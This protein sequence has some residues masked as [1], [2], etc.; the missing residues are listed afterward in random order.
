MQQLSL[1]VSRTAAILFIVSSA[2]RAQS[3]ADNQFQQEC[4][5]AGKRVERG[6]PEKKLDEAFLTLQACGSA[7][8]SR[9]LASALQSY[10]GE[11]DPLR[12]QEFM[13]NVDSWRDASVLQAARDV[14]SSTA[15]TMEARV[16]AIRHLL[17]LAN[18][19]K[20]YAYAGLVAGERTAAEANGMQI[21]TIGCG[22]MLTSAASDRV[23]LPLPPDYEVRIQSTLAALVASPSTPPTVRNAARCGMK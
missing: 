6:H 16:F 7:A 13:R 9:A 3:N 19:T 18:P 14:A 12:L 4:D 11:G 22:E 2:A 8:T 15:A 1:F 5:K 17:V 20:R 10:A 21:T 23:G